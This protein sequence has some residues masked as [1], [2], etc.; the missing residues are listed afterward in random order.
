MLRCNLHTHT[1]FCDGKDDCESLVLCA[2]EKGFDT[3]G[4]S[5]HSYTFFDESYCM[6]K[7]DTKRY[8]E[9]ISALKQKYR[10]KI[11]ILCGIEQD[12]Y[13]EESTEGYDFV[14]GSVHYILMNG[15]YIEIDGSSEQFVKSVQK[16][17]NGDFYVFAKKY[18]E[19]VGMVYE[20]TKADIIGHF[21]LITKFNE[22]S[23]LFDESDPRY[24]NCA[25]KA[26]E[27]I[28]LSA[29]KSI[30]TGK[31]SPLTSESVFAV[32]KDISQFGKEVHAPIF[33]I[34]TGAMA[35]GYKTQPYPSKDILKM[36]KNA[37]GKLIFSSDCHDKEFLD[38]AYDEV[39]ALSYDV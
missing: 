25:Q 14:I 18:Y 4:F 36:I 2:I 39:L 10:G 26:V 35:R 29:E 16:H 5:G 23:R 19:T 22:N 9:E 24:L 7:D 21:D 11:K 15:E 32:Q 3:L 8:R 38:F 12:F 6:S 28:M 20:K 1:K 37:G 34:N 33:E 17:T 13:S 31:K 27:S 30:N